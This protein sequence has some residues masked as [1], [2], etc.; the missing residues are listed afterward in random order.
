MVGF[1]GVVFG[2]ELGSAGVDGRGMIFFG[3]GEFVEVELLDL[4]RE[5]LFGFVGAQDG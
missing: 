5:G 1:R 2:R 3:V 4:E